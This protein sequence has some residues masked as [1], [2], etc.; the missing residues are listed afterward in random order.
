MS[1]SSFLLQPLPVEEPASCVEG[2]V[3]MHQTSGGIVWTENIAPSSFYTFQWSE[4][5]HSI[6]VM[7]HNSL[8]YSAKNNNMTLV[9]QPKREL[10]NS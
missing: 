10:M 1:F 6:T 9:R 5:I 2:L 4:D 3:V 8:G 7:S